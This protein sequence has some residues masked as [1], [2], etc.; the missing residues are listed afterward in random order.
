MVVIVADHLPSG[1]RAGSY[2]RAAAAGRQSQQVVYYDRFRHF[3]GAVEAEEQAIVNMNMSH[4]TAE[5]T[6]EAMPEACSE[7]RLELRPEERQKAHSVLSAHFQ[8]ALKMQVLKERSL[9]P[10]APLGLSQE[11]EQEVLEPA[12]LS[13]EG[14]LQ[15]AVALTR[16]LTCSLS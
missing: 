9:Q 7:A 11:P 14:P 8:A 13:P 16:L 6:S 15:S 4:S 2:V 10:L 1:L 12:P 5:S 3:A